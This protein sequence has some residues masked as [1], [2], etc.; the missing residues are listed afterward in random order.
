MTS[1]PPAPPFGELVDERPWGK[2]EQFSLNQSSTVK[3]IT[4]A[5]GRRLSLQRHEHR[6]ELWVVLDGELVV[7]QDGV[8]RTV[9]RDGRVW[10]PRGTDHRVANP[11]DE[12]RRFLEVAFGHFDEDDI[13][14]I[15]DDHGRL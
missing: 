6:D 10:L 7:H 4:V 12:P 2:F 11:G 15:E 1:Q 9:G 5:P 3:I 13:E 8:E 14:R